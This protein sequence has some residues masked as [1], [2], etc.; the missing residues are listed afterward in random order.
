MAT[1]SDSETRLRRYLRDPDADVWSQKHLI[2]LF[3]EA[4][5]R[6]NRDIGILQKI[7]GIHVP[8]RTDYTRCYLWEEN[9]LQG[10]IRKLGNYYDAAEYL[11]LFTWEIEQISGYGPQSEDG[12]RSCYSWEIYS[13]DGGVVEDVDVYKFPYDYD[14]TVYIAYDRE[15]LF[16]ISEE[17]VRSDHCSYKTYSGEPRYYYR[18]NQD[19][20]REFALYPRPSSVVFDEEVTCLADSDF[21]YSFDWEYDNDHAPPGC[22]SSVKFTETSNTYECIYPWEV[23]FIDGYTNPPSEYDSYLYYFTNNFSVDIIEHYAG[24]IVGISGEGSEGD[25]GAV[26]DMDS[27]F[28]ADEYGIPV[29][30]VGLDDNIFLIYKTRTTE[31]TSA[32]DTVEGWLDWQIKYIERLVASMALRINNDRFSVALADIWYKRYIDGLEVMKRYKGRRTAGRRPSLKT[33]R[34]P[35]RLKRRVDLPDTYPSA[36][37]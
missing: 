12:Y 33:H 3:N 36:W 25:L 21:G 34:I 23:M 18:I 14:E 32:T 28:M 20:E 27:A 2:Q 16:H 8:A 13:I 10:A 35:T 22:A 7:G 31:I 6:F 26:Y 1:F 4:Q 37:K 17:E 19:E 15:K 29:D 30:F 9:Y 11:C 24:A 5:H